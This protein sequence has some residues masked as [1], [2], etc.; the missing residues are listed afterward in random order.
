MSAP[1]PVMASEVAGHVVEAA[2]E[3][4]QVAFGQLA[5]H[6]DPAMRTLAYR[7]LGDTARMDDALQEAYVKAYRALPHF[8]GGSTSRVV[9]WITRHGL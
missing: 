9:S 1:A 7:L 6:Y 8:H 5:R 3:G 4:D 2:R